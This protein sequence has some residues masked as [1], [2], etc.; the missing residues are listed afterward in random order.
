MVLRQLSPLSEN[1]TKKL[2]KGVCFESFAAQHGECS[3]LLISVKKPIQFTRAI[4]EP[5]KFVWHN[6]E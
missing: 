5:L 6:K 2:V 4:S 3:Y 1:A